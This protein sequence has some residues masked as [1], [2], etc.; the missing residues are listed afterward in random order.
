[1][2]GALGPKLELVNK[3]SCDCIGVGSLAVSR[4]RNLGHNKRGDFFT[5]LSAFYFKYFLKE[6]ESVI[7][8]FLPHTTQRSEP[9]F[10]IRNGGWDGCDASHT[11]TFS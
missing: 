8:P 11:W 4:I 1:M 9:S 6:L 3:P 10:S 2:S 7:E 5:P